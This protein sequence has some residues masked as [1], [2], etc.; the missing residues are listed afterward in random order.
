M[1]RGGSSR[2]ISINGES[3]VKDRILL[4]Q[5]KENSMRI[6]RTLIVLLV[7][8]SITGCA[9]RTKKIGG[10]DNI[11]VASADGPL[12]DVNFAFDSSKIDSRAMDILKMNAS[13]LK[14]NADSTV[15]IEGHCDE[16]GTQEY[17]L[18]LGSRRAQ[19]CY[20]VLKSLGI[21]S[22]RM[23]T[24]SYG[25]ELPLDPGHNEAAWAKNRRC[26]FSVK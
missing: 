4:L 1:F 22:K 14:E 3:Q 18:A 8:L 20:G 16:R 12:K 9:C 15:Q 2:I 17:N 24:I 25:E 21:D 10:A 7:A 13:W 26:H 5:S 6:L 23:S 19:S 11:P